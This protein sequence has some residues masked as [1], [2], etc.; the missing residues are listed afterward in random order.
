[1]AADRFVYW[2][3]RK[4][5]QAEVEAVLRNFFDEAATEIKWDKDRFFVTLVGKKSFVF[6]GLG[7]PLEAAELADITDTRWGTGPIRS[8]EIWLGSDTLD[9]M[10][11]HGDAFTSA[12]ADG[13]VQ[14]FA[15]FW[16]GRVET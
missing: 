3:E 15:R 9:V 14:V 8:I 10:T 12:L 2:A 4:P 11:R 6:K 7:H 5:T 1:M 16:Q 13:L